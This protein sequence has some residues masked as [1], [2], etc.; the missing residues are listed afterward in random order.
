MRNGKSELQRAIV[1][2]LGRPY[3][4]DVEQLNRGLAKSGKDSAGLTRNVP[5]SVLTGDP[6]SLQTG[7]CLGVFGINPRCH[8]IDGERPGHDVNTSKRLIDFGKY[9]AYI[10]R[11]ASYF[12]A[13]D[14]QYYSGYFDRLIQLIQTGMLD[15]ENRVI[16]DFGAQAF[17]LDLLPWW[18]ENTRDLREKGCGVHLE[19]LKAWMGLVDQFIRSLEPVAIVVN[20]SGLRG[21]SEALFQTNF[22]RFNYHEGERS[23]L[24]AYWGTHPSGTPVLLHGPVYQAS[25]PQTAERYVQMLKQWQVDSGVNWRELANKILKPS[26]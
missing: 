23:N 18:S 13:G 7:K 1:E 2:F 26:H 3:A 22:N 21:W 19:P 10:K 20:S 12:D 16:P 15:Y 25:G 17:K 4:S 11:R 8:G 9:D 5:P 6:L 24:Y 14:P